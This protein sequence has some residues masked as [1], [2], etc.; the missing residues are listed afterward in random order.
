[1]IFLKFFVPET[2][3]IT[4]EQLESNLKAGKA[5]KDLGNH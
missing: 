3:G 1:M 4:L 5:L 2:K